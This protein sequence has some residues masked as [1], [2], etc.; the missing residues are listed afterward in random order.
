MSSAIYK[1][2]HLSL[3][4]W[5]ALGRS[6]LT[7]WLWINFIS[8]LLLL[9][10]MCDKSEIQR[11]TLLWFQISIMLNSFVLQIIKKEDKDPQIKQEFSTSVIQVNNV[12]YIFM[13]YC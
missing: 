3:G 2:L 12:W 13:L 10:R 9:I 1:S 5:G 4:G 8:N 7:K 6:S 11:S